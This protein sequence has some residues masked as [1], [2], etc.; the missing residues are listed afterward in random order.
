MMLVVGQEG[1]QSGTVDLP[2][3][4]APDND[5]RRIRLERECH[6]A[7]AQ[8]IAVPQ[9]APPLNLGRLFVQKRAVA[10]A[11]VFDGVAR[12]V[13][14]DLAM[15]AADGADLNDD[16]A[17]RMATQDVLLAVERIA[18]A[19]LRPVIRLQVEHGQIR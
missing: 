14:D 8:L 18:F 9:L 16:L 3:G 5:R 12:A 17:V 10:A 15:V 7:H 19:G 4:Q 13:L 11:E 1:A 6:L 2:A